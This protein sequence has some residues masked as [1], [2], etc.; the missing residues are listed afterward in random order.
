MGDGSAVHTPSYSGG[1]IVKYPPFTPV[2]VLPLS[3]FGSIYDVY[4]GW[5]R[6]DATYNELTPVQRAKYAAGVA[7]IADKVYT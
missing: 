4:T 7:T 1:H 2:C 6:Y 5:G 3:V